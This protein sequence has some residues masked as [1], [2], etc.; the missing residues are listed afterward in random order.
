MPLLL[1]PALLRCLVNALEGPDRLLRPAATKTL[2]SL[3]HAAESSP[4][5]RPALVSGL[6]GRGKVLGGGEYDRHASTKALRQLLQAAPSLASGS[7]GES[8]SSESITYLFQLFASG[9][10]SD[11]AGAGA[12]RRA[13]ANGEDEEAVA[14]KQRDNSRIW[15]LDQ[16]LVLSRS[17]LPRSGGKATAT[18]TL[19]L[20]PAKPPQ[21]PLRT[22]RFLFASAFW[23]LSG[24]ET[25]L[26]NEFGGMPMPAPSTAVRRACADRLLSIMGESCTAM[27][28]AGGGSAGGRDE[29]IAALEVLEHV[30]TWWSEMESAGGTLL[31]TLNDTEQAA[32]SASQSL[33]ESLR[34]RRNLSSD[35]AA[36]LGA[37][38]GGGGASKDAH[39]HKL[40]A[41]ELFA[42]HMMLQLLLGQKS[43]AGALDEIKECVNQVD[44]AALTSSVGSALEGRID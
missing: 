2:E 42:R 5:L 16:L 25:A 41:L 39:A 36:M 17:S 23:E 24:S 9:H 30:T 28:S 35:A 37:G 44:A 1:S 11:D 19:L 20:L 34:K 27:A 40:R 21:L 43:A 8:E 3:A 6:L 12:M 18:R 7:E 33:V 29:S 22:L 32:L 4:T 15:A 10:Q 26:V 14:A 31:A 13:V 38:G